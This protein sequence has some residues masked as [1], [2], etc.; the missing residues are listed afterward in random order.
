MRAVAVAH[1]QSQSSTTRQRV[2]SKTYDEGK[3]S[4]RD[5]TIF[6]V[7]S[8]R[9]SNNYNS[10]PKNKSSTEYLLILNGSPCQLVAYKSGS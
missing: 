1:V 4:V 2:P 6:S 3:V 7:D 10:L 5:V 9:L 8:E